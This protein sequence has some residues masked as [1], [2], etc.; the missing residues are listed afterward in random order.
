MRLKMP[1][2][3]RFLMI[4]N[5]FGCYV[6]HFILGFAFLMVVVGYVR[7]KRGKR[8]KFSTEKWQ[9]F[10][11]SFDTGAIVRQVNNHN[12]QDSGTHTPK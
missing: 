4:Y 9:E 8:K 6:K 1:H 10:R 12:E 11:Y 5:V 7:K 2:D 3:H